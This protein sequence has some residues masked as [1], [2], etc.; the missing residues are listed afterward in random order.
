MT[1]E[2]CIPWV[3][4]EDEYYTASELQRLVECVSP[5]YR[6]VGIIDTC[7]R[8]REFWNSCKGIDLII[9]DESLADGPVSK[10]FNDLEVKTPVIVV[11]SNEGTR[12]VDFD[13]KII[14]ILLHPVEL[15]HMQEALFT[16]EKYP[17]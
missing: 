4:L 12:P 1:N 7:Q 17:V 6:N 10:V 2:K 13:V 11:T 3:L 14:S 15:S 8:F 5:N 16:F 9:A